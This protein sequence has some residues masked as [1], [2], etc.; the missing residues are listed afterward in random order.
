MRIVIDTNIWISGLLWRGMSWNLLRLA[1]ARRVELCIAPGMLAELADVLSYPRL[2]PRLNQLGLQPPDLVVYALNLSAVFDCPA[3][4]MEPIVT[5][6]SD[7]DIFLR[8]AVVAKADYVISGDQHL[9][10]MVAYAGIPIVTI[11]DF[12]LHDFPDQVIE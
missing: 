9:L 7:D 6:D 3:I 11:K 4:K 1:E 2:R 10:T 12:L 5:A 8:C